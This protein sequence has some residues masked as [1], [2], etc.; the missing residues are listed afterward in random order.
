MRFP[1]ARAPKPLL[2]PEAE[3]RLSARQQEILDA[4]EN[5]LRG[6][7][8]ARLTMAEI[9]ARFSCS[10]RTLYGIAPSKD[11]LILMIVDRRLHRIG[12]AAMESLDHSLA[13]LAALRTYLSAVNVAVQPES[14]ALAEA[15]GHVPGAQHVIDAH[16]R[17]VIAVTRS[18]LE[19][20][21]AAGEIREVDTAAAAHVLGGLGRSFDRLGAEGLA[22]ASPR[23]AADAMA[24]VILRGLA[25]AAG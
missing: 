19:R 21:R 8:L 24:D 11:E 9:A 4:L 25:V 14:V 2:G 7:E 22:A 6:E 3:A 23:A 1:G 20:A 16:E 5:D 17:Y 10:L 18:L 15:L 12:R 13:P